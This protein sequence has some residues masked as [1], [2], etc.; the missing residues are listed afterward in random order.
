MKNF[1]EKY[2]ELRRY[3]LKLFINR[4]YDWNE[5][6][7]RVIKLEDAKYKLEQENKML[8]ESIEYYKK[9]AEQTIEEKLELYVSDNLSEFN[10]KFPRP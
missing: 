1:K 3:D 2:G 9:Q 6:F 5:L 10:K 7:L 4:A 8:K